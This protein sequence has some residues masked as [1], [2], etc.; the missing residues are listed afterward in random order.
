MIKYTYPD[1]SHCYR[2]LHTTHAVFRDEPGA[3]V[4]KRQM[5]RFTNSKL[6]ALSCS[7]PEFAMTS[8]FARIFCAK[9]EVLT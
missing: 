4:R 8:A 3:R 7:S 5:A 1:G 2:A 9:G 6:P